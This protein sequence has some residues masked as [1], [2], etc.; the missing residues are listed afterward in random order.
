MDLLTKHY[1]SIEQNRVSIINTFIPQ[2]RI[3]ST[4]A[5]FSRRNRDCRRWN[6]FAYHV[7]FTDE[8]DIYPSFARCAF[9]V[10]EFSRH[11]QCRQFHR[12]SHASDLIAPI[13]RFISSVSLPS[14]ISCV[15]WEVP[16]VANALGPNLTISQYKLGFR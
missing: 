15:L 7:I 12:F 13:S 9:F 4:S 8:R 11:Y 10:G 6:H 3:N 1:K 2:R 5:D 16:L 14:W